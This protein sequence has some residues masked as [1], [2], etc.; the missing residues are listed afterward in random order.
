MPKRFLQALLHPDHDDDPERTLV[1]DA[2][3]LLQV[4]EFQLIELAFE[5]WHGRPMTAAESDR[6][7][8]LFMLEGQNLPFALHYARQILSLESE[9]RLDGN[10]AEYHRFDSDYFR[11]PMRD[12]VRKLV[13]VATMLVGVLG[14]SLILAS[15]SIE[16]NGKCVGELPPCIS[17]RVVPSR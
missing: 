7:F 2:A 17:E 15:Q 9:G 1:I 3:N 4:G 5:R 6:Y 8:A 12:G 11:V 16:R 13:V 14:G 10:A